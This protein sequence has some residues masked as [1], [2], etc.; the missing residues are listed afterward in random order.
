MKAAAFDY[1]RPSTV[2]EVCHH[3]AD[4]ARDARII[5]GGQSLVPMMAMRLVRPEL[6]ID[7]NAVPELQGISRDGNEVVI[8]ACTRQAE[9]TRSAIVRNHLPLLAKALAFVGHDQIRN[10]GTIGGSLAHAD[11]SAEIGLVAVTLDATV[12]LVASDGERRLTAADFLLAPMTTAIESKECLAEVRFPATTTPARTG[13]GFH[14]VS[15]RDSDFAIVAAS[16]QLT[17]DAEGTVTHAAVAVAN[18]GP[19]P[20]RLPDVEATLVGTRP[21]AATVKDLGR[22]MDDRLDPDGD[23]H[24]SARARRRIAQSLVARAV[25][26]AAAPIDGNG[27]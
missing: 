25:L 26:D 8:R 1:V 5:A 17:L 14:E 15:A 22:L 6:L 16:A 13:V 12:L 24:A 11:P 9:G 18:A 21:T 27:S 3:L 2:A 20:V 23:V 4:D 19:V 10:R 7:I